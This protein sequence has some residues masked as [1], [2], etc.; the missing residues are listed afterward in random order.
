[1]PSY[2]LTY[3]DI[4]GG[5]AEPV[6]IGLH[7]AGIEFEDNRISF[8]EFGEQRG[9]M[10]FRAVPVLEIDGVQVTQSNALSRYVG[11]MSG[12]YPADPLQA[13]YCDEVMGAMEDLTHYVVQ[14]FGLE[15]EALVEARKQLTETRIKVFLQGTADLLARGGGTYFADGQMTMADLKAFV[16][17]RSLASGLLDHVPG[18]IV[19]TLTPSLMEH[20][21]RISEDSRVV[22]YYQ[23]RAQ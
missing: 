10:R 20:Q 4:D 8:Q 19:Q 11:R 15:G 9:G 16:Q 5:R 2:K 13:L 7:S 17:V 12:L 6:R 1:M 23:S 21:Q 14:T 18:D 3:F 22:A